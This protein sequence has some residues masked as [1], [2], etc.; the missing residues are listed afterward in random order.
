MALP[1]LTPSDAEL[2]LA[3]PG[4]VK[5]IIGDVVDDVVDAVVADV[6]ADVVEAPLVDEVVLGEVVEKPAVGEVNAIFSGY[7]SGLQPKITKTESKALIT[8]VQY[9]FSIWRLL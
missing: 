1:P 5:G 6:V 9:L 7:P 8:T 2:V 4:V 3:P